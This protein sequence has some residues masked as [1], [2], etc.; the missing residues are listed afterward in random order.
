MLYI[1][2]CGVGGDG[3]FLER[4]DSKKERDEANYDLYE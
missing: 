1:L 3:L 4:G 2:F